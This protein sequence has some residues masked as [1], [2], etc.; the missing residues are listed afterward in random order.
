MLFE[1]INENEK[2]KYIFDNQDESV[3]I[4]KEDE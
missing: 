1:N 3:I 2:F 4:I